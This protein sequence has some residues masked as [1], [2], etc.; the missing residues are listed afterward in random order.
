[1]YLNCHSY[2]SLRFGTISVEQ[3]VEDAS[4]CGIDALA[5]T[6][7]NCSTGV[8]DFVKACRDFDIKPIVG[9]DFRSAND[10]LYM[11]IA[12]NTAGLKE[13]NDFL[14]HHNLQHLKIPEQPGEFENVF[15]I[16]PFDKAP[17]KLRENEYIGIHYTQLNRL[18][19]FRNDK[20]LKRLVIHHPVTFRTHDEYNL[21]KLL[22]CVRN[23]IIIS[24]LQS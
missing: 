15:V 12:K 24:K 19:R 10:Q 3:L 6:D 2:H 13:I 23:N 9:I 22:V 20:V 8:F 21:H 17:A 16:Y 18:F 5:L 4:R 1:M 7:I 14:T 11:C